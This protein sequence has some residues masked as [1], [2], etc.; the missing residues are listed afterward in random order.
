M[1]TALKDF[2]PTVALSRS[3]MFGGLLAISACAYAP[4]ALAGCP[5]VTTGVVPQKSISHTWPPG[6]V[7]VIVPLTTSTAGCP[8]GNITITGGSVHVELWRNG[9]ATPYRGDKSIPQ[10]PGSNT[11]NI[12]VSVQLSPQPTAPP[13]VG[14]YDVKHSEVVYFSDGSIGT[15]GPIV[16]VSSKNV[17]SFEFHKGKGREGK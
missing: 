11:Q 8:G 17:V 15:H 10:G 13:N 7:S 4:G 9:Q 12:S 1:K 16:V 5:T 2:I 14:L 6:S 3:H